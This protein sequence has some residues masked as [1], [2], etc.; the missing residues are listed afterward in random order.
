MSLAGVISAAVLAH[1]CAALPAPS[2]KYVAV[3]VVK[4]DEHTK[5]TALRV[6]V[7]GRRVELARGTFHE[8]RGGV[9]VGAASAAGNRVAWIE[10]HARG[11]TRTAVVTLAAVGREVRVLRR[12]TA[13]RERTRSELLTDVLLTRQGDLAWSAGTYGGPGGVVAV[14]QPGRR[15]RTLARAEGGRLALEDGRT[16]RWLSGDISYDFFDLHPIDC[17]SRSR[18]TPYAR[19]DRVLL[20]R[21]I[22]RPNHSEVSVVRGCDLR[23]GHDRVLVQNDSNIGVAS[24][25]TLIGIDRTWAV[26]RQD[27]GDGR[28]YAVSTVT[29]ADV[30]TDRSPLIQRGPFPVASAPFAVTDAGRAAWIVAGTL[31]GTDRDY[32]VVTLDSGG[33]LSDL[34]AEGDALVWTRDGVVKRV[35]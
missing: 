10:E 14:K 15:T 12:F 8:D 27:A 22:Y 16:L 24:D 25:L 17:R 19:T 4:V 13:H 23:T 35:R 11:R 26:F 3:S 31:Y 30:V 9:R 2:A 5:R 34:H 18:F 28:D 1:G 20:T 7:G 32:D 29:V 33:V 21:A 6:C